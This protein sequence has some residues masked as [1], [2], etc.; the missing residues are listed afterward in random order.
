MPLNQYA[1]ASSAILLVTMVT[2][3][4]L[5]PK[6]GTADWY[7]GS[8]KKSC[9]A[10]KR[11]LSPMLERMEISWPTEGCRARARA[12]LG[13]MTIEEKVGQMV[14]PDRN[15]LQDDYVVAPYGMGS[16]LSGGDSDPPTNAAADWART[17]G[18]LHEISLESRLKIPLLYGIDAVHG[19]NNVKDTVIFPHNIGLGCTRN[20]DLLKQIGRVT[21][22]EVAATGIDWTF[23]PV[24]AASR[25]ERWGRAYEAFGET[26]ELAAQL[27]TALVIGLQG[28]RLGQQ[29]PAVLACA[30]HFAGDG[31]TG[32]GIDRGNVV[33][34]KETFMRLHVE[35][36]RAAIAAGVGSIMVSFSSYNG[37]MMHCNGELLSD[38]LKG[39]L[40][41]TGFLVSDWEAVEL[42]P[43]AYDTQVTNAI[44]AG[45]DMVMAPRSYRHFINTLQSLVPD[46]IPSARI[47]D[48]VGRILAVKCELGLLDPEHFPR[49]SRGA[50]AA[51]SRL[52]A[53]LGSPDHRA[54]AREAVRQSLVLL[55]NAD[56]LLPLRKNLG[57]VHVSGKNAYNLGNQCGGWT[58]G[59]QGGSGAV[60]AGTTILEAIRGAV[61]N[62]AEVSYSLD[63]EN[64]KG[65]KVAIAVIGERPYAEGA[66]DRADLNLDAEDRAVI[67]NISAA[68]VPMVVI[69]VSGRPLILGDSVEKAKAII[70][71]W[72]PGSEGGGVADVL[73]GD[74]A[75]TGKLSVS[76]PRRMEQ[77]PINVGDADYD[78]L[79]PYGFGLTYK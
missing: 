69:V 12:L 62:A 44:N 4:C 35:Q 77:I 14:Q 60:T 40:G 47:D 21:A 64:A 67:D 57:R 33:M 34:D 3:S 74:Y 43:G 50:I 17:V 37:V 71:A 31:G 73:F 28:E 55:K 18:R 27:G 48:A 79:Y 2:G 32:Q 59:W 70:A 45:V 6:T 11:S 23:A 72:L 78:P 13:Q 20:P 8:L 52:L 24:F 54:V 15:Q 49:D 68:G 39:D 30:K 63:G 26:P 1:L 36:Y 56:D 75:P 19:H 51:N 76:W 65:A 61:S 42:L 66:G 16:V 5:T 53:K 25:D 41:F 38:T 22:E 7:E 46:K 10:A 9:V 29:T 58:I